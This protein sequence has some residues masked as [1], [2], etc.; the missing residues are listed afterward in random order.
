MFRYLPLFY[1]YGLMSYILISLFFVCF[2]LPH[3]ENMIHA[4][5]NRGP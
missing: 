2:L 5:T 1:P 3:V 4:S